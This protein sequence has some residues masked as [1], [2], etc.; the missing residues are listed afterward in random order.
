MIVIKEYGVKDKIDYVV[1]HDGS[2]MVAYLRKINE[3]LE[4]DS[5]VED[6]DSEGETNIAD[7]NTESDVGQVEIIYFDGVEVTDDQ[8]NNNSRDD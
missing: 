3:D 6:D 4:E 7:D 1:P 8:A 5:D 2:N